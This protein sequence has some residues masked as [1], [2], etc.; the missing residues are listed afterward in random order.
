M[1]AEVKA[2]GPLNW[3]ARQLDRPDRPALSLQSSSSSSL[4][5]MEADDGHDGNN[6]KPKFAMYWAAACGG[7]EI[8]VLNIHE[9]ILDVDANF[10]VV[11][12][13]VAM[14]AKYKDVE[15]MA[16]GSHH[17]LP[18]Q[19][20]DPQR[21]ERAD[22]APAAAQSQDPGRLR[23]VRVR[24]LHPGLANLYSKQDMLDTA[25]STLST[26]NPQDI[27]PQIELSCARRGSAH[28]AT[29]IETVK[30][31]D[32]VVPVDYYMPGCPP[33]IAADR[34]RGRAG[35]QGAEGR[36]AAAAGRVR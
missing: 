26:D 18:F 33:E 2:L 19:R 16:D 12:W 32:Q 14:D 10:D 3:K 35:D 1:V 6:G 5:R 34:G 36:G 28:S 22:R 15:A 24:G 13:P 4:A 25:F 8:A 11:F 17:A 20:R 30:T 7:C 31:L 29:C 9:R 21:R 23:L 27:R